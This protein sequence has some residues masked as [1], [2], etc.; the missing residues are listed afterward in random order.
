MSLEAALH[1]IDEGHRQDPTLVDG[2]PYELH[3]AN[4]CTRY[5]AM[6]NAEASELL[7][8][9]VRA[10]HLRRFEVPRSSYPLGKNGYLAWRTFLK[11]RQGAMYVLSSCH[12]GQID[13]KANAYRASAICK[14]AGYSE[15]DAERVAAMIRK[16]NYKTD[17][18]T[19]T[20]EDVACLCFLDD[21][22][23]AF[24]LEHDEDKVVRIVQKTWKKMSGA[25]QQLALS[26]QMN[27]ECARVV[28]RALST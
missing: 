1:A 10:Q 26:M 15:A 24:A 20:L 27:D 17:A 14:E 12:V 13:R 28:Q 7:R 8:L 22:F 19:Q 2:V 4:K 9:A 25:G 21:Q 18:E 3:Y 11:R 16:D 6:L 5:L 23:A